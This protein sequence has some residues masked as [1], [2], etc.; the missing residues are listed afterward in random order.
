[1]AMGLFPDHDADRFMLVGATEMAAD[2]TLIQSERLDLIPMTPP[3]LE[4]CLAGDLATATHLLDL[5]MPPDWLQAQWLMQLSLDQLLQNRD[6]QPWLLRA[7]GLRE[8]RV[9][10]GHIGFHSQP[11]PDYLRDVAPDGVEFGYT[12]FAPFRRQGYATEA[13]DALMNWVHQIHLVRRF[14]VSISP[15][16]VPSLRIAQHFGFRKVGT[17]IDEED[18]PEDI[19]VREIADAT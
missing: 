15:D 14:V 7:I 2:I 4:A 16:N 3:F 9:M 19:F 11:G 10:I 12:I 6:L 18:G 5:T 17:Q 13:C 1:M 8:Q